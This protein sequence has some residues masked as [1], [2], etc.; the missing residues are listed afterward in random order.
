VPSRYNGVESSSYQYYFT[1][2]DLCAYEADPPGW[3]ARPAAQRLRHY[4]NNHGERRFFRHEARMH[5]TASARPDRSPIVFPERI[6]LRHLQYRS[7]EQI[8]RRL[9]HRRATG[10]GAFAH[11]KDSK[12]GL[13]LPCPPELSDQEPWRER[14]ADSALL[15]LDR[16]DGLLVAREAELS[17]LPPVLGPGMRHADGVRRA[18]RRSQR[19][20]LHALRG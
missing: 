10:G 19:A 15:D 2:V 5:W 16:G 7:P 20:L 11:E 13:F 18:L 9:S 3:L 6:R 4:R 8:T 17:P 12:L 1:D 14:V